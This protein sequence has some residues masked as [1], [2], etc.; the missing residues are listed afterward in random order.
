M[1]GNLQMRNELTFGWI[2]FIVVLTEEQ[3]TDNSNCSIQNR[4]KCMGEKET[5]KY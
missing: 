3:R 1:E 5:G 4:L 2:T